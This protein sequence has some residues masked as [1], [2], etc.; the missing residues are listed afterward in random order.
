LR[1]LSPI[2]AAKTALTPGP[3]DGG[4]SGMLTGALTGCGKLEQPSLVIPRPAEG[5]NPE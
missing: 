4:F 5:R 2:P 3:P 1:T